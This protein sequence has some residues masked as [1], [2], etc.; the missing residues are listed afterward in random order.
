M[1]PYVLS[2]I[3]GNKLFKLFRFCTISDG[4]TAN[5]E[6]K[7]SIANIKPDEKEFDV[8]IRAFYDTDANPVILERYAKCTMDPTSANYIGRKV[9]T[10]DGFYEPKSSYVLVELTDDDNI[11]DAFPAGFD[12]VAIR[13]YGTSLAP[14]IEYKKTYTTVE[15]KRKAYLGISN[16]TGID[17]DFFNYKGLYNDGSSFTGKTSA[18]HLDVNATNVV[19]LDNQPITF[20]TGNAVFQNEATLQGT[21]Y[22]KLYARKFTF[23]PFGGFDGWDT[24]R[25]RRTNTDTYSKNASGK[26]LKGLN[27]GTIVL[28]S[29]TNGD[30]G[31]SSDYFAFLEAIRT[32][33][34]PEAVNINVL[35]T[36]GIDIG[37]NSNLVEETIEMVEQERADS[38]YIVTTP[39]FDGM[40]A[41]E[42][43]AIVDDSGLDS[44]YTATYWPWVQINDTENNVLLYV[45]PTRDVVRNIAITD[46]VAFPWSICCSIVTI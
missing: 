21:D 37:D 43:V 15:N 44:N 31:N 11:F 24:Y 2:E 34:N 30:T 20:E 32:Y 22:E 36:P 17:Q 12:G 7:I 16:I 1:T 27:E 41:E 33:A 23:A 35:A 14:N 39:D 9:G 13:D 40:T 5:E 42:A 38:L 19:S 18:F 26:A 10:I 3:R 4:N 8:L 45:P 25:T 28:R 29:L 46:N 6:I